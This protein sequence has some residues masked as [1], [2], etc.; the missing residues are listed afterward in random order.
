MSQ[1]ISMNPPARARRQAPGR[2]GQDT[3]TPGRDPLAAFAAILIGTAATAASGWAA[4]RT[5][6][7]AGTS[8]P[9]LTVACGILVT[10]AMAL[11]FT[12]RRV[13]AVL[14][15]CAAAAMPWIPAI[16]F[17][18]HVWQLAPASTRG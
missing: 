1:T 3:L 17:L 12:R 4:G 13:L 2:P 18:H 6:A 9:L 8:H 11:A 10:A 16:D 7:M 14:L 15:L 5:A